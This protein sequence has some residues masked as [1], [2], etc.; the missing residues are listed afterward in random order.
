MPSRSFLDCNSKGVVATL[1]SK[2]S[3]KNL[4]IKDKDMLLTSQEPS[5]NLD[6][7]LI[8]D[9]NFRVLANFL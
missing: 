8:M 3:P 7:L 9:A 1:I 6:T 2:K 5:F 4:H